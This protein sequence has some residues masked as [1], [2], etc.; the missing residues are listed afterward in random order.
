[1]EHYKKNQFLQQKIRWNIREIRWYCSMPTELP[2]DSS[3]GVIFIG[4]W[5][6]TELFSLVNLT[7]EYKLTNNRNL[8]SK[9]TKIQ[10]TW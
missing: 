10:P 1:M 8:F 9:T 2:H 3:V 5:L 4:K 7:T 6:T